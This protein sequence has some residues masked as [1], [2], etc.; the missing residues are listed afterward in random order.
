LALRDA[1][2]R[3]LADLWDGEIRVSPLAE[4]PSAVTDRLDQHLWRGQN[5]ALTPVIDQLRAA[6]EDRVRSTVG[7]A[8]VD[9]LLTGDG[10]SARPAAHQVTRPVLEVGRMAVAV[11]TGELRVT[12][13]ERKL[14]YCLRD[15]RNS[16]AHLV[17]LDDSTLSR[18][19]QAIA[20]SPVRSR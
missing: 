15:V 10:E 18:L 1:W 3:G 17:A 20:N 16:L 5:R 11:K 6:M 7:A 9:A 8:G 2:N 12:E 14:I 4:E 19:A 13:P